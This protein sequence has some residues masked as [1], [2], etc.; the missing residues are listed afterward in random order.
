M[1][2]RQSGFAAALV[3]DLLIPAVICGVVIAA[4]VFSINSASGSTAAENAEI[5]EQ[6]IRRAAIA[7]YAAEGIYPDSMDYLIENYNLK[8]DTDRFLILYRSVASNIMPDIRVS[9]KG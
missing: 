1:K 5:T 4:V 2:L 6:G 8:V 3:K 7:C 9:A